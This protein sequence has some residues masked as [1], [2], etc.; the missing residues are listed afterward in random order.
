MHPPVQRRAYVVFCFYVETLKYDGKRASGNPVGDEVCS[1]D[2]LRGHIKSSGECVPGV[3]VCIV[4]VLYRWWCIMAK[5]L[6]KQHY[7]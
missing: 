2:V 3:L 1:L 4:Y 7:P 5:P 6:N